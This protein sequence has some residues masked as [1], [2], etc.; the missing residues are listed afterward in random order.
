MMAIYTDAEGEPI[1]PSDLQTSIV[2]RRQHPSFAVEAPALQYSL[3]GEAWPLQGC[4]GCKMGSNI[5]EVRNGIHCECIYRT[6]DV[7]EV[8]ELQKVAQG[9]AIIKALQCQ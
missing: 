8:I 1:L 6:H 4:F 3:H 7:L 9:I 2:M 5:R